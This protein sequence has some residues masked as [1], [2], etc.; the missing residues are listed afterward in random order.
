M[1]SIDLNLTVHL[2]VVSRLTVTILIY[3]IKF[4]KN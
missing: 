3:Q 4:K 1:Y 2:L